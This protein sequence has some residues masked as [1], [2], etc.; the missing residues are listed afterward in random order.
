MFYKVESTFPV[1][2]PDNHKHP[3][4]SKKT[5]KYFYRSKVAMLIQLEQDLTRKGTVKI[6]EISETE[7]VRNVNANL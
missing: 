3:Y 4:R 6:R 1:V 5:Y 2:K 7:Y